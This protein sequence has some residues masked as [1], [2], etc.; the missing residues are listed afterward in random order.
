MRK[1]ILALVAAATLVLALAGTAAAGLY[2]HR[3]ETFLA[4]DGG[5]RVVPA[6]GGWV[7]LEIDSAFLGDTASYE[8]IV[9]RADTGQLV[10]D[11]PCVPFRSDGEDRQNGAVLGT[12]IRVHGA[13]VYD[14]EIELCSGFAV[15]TQIRAI[16]N[17][18]KFQIIEVVV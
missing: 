11:G 8:L 18:R 14:A 6:T 17:I 16:T 1:R 4:P 5:V 12:N 3:V 15:I 7:T 13:R 10:Y 9:R 2:T